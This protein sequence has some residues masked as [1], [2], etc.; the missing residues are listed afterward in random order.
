MNTIISRRLSTFTY[1]KWQYRNGQ[2]FPDGPGIL[3]NGGAGVV[4]G[5]DLLSGR[6]LESRS[7]FIPVGV[8]TFVTD[9][10]LDRL[11]EIDKFK[12]DIDRGL[13][14]VVKGKKCSQEECD[15]IASRD[16]IPNDRIEERPFSQEDIENAG[17]VFNDDG[18]VDISKAAEDIVGLRKANA[19][20]PLYVQKRNNENAIEK[21]RGRPRKQK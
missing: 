17:G 3:I 21:K 11:Y 4:G 2:A 15:N 5:A 6:P 20:A 14:T 10:V 8:M 13:I 1:Q 7:R 18:S 19:G 16:M 12:R 9:A